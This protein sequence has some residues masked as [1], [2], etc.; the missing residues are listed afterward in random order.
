VI[1]WIARSVMHIDPAP[2]IARLEETALRILQHARVDGRGADAVGR[3]MAR[4]RID[5]ARI[6]VSPPPSPPA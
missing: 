6:K 1:D 2:L 4:S 5:T 3:E